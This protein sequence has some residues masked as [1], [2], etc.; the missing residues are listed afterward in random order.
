MKKLFTILFWGILFTVGLNFQSQAQ[1]CPE[2]YNFNTG[3]SHVILVN[4]PLTLDGNAI[5]TSPADDVYVAAFYDSSGY[6]RCAGYSIWQGV[7]TSITAWGQESTAIENGYAAGELLKFKFC[8]NGD[9]YD[10]TP[11]FSFGPSTYSTNGLSGLC[12]LS[13]A[14][15]INLE[16]VDWIGPLS[17]CGLGV[18]SVTV[19]IWNDTL[20]MATGPFDISYSIDNGVNWVTETYTGS[21]TGQDTLVYTFST[22]ANFSA[23][24][25]TPGNPQDSV[26][27]VAFQITFTSDMDSTD[28]YF[29]GTVTNIVPPQVNITNSVLELCHPTNIAPILLTASPSGGTFSFDMSSG[30]MYVIGGSFFPS[31]SGPGQW[32]VYYD[33]YDQTTGCTG[34]DTVVFSV[35]ADPVTHITNT[36]LEGC[37][38]DTIQINATPAGGT[39]TGTWVDPT[40]GVFTP[41]SPNTYTI[42][43]SYTDIHGCSDNTSED[44][45]IHSLPSVSLDFFRAQCTDGQPF[46]LD[47]QPANGVFEVDQTVLPS[48]EFNPANFST[49]THTVYYTYTD[50]YG[51]SKQTS[52]TIKIF[53]LPNVNFTGLDAEYCRYDAPVTL[54]GTP[55]NGI[56]SGATSTNIFDPVNIG[57]QSITYTYTQDNQFYGDTA[58]C[59]NHNTQSTTV[60]AL[61]NIDISAAYTIN[62]WG[63]ISTGMPDSIILNAGLGY[64]AYEWNTG[65]TT[66]SITNLPWGTYSCSVTDDHSC[67]GTD[68]VI[69]GGLDIS[70]TMLLNPVSN[71]EQSIPQEF[72]Y[73]TKNSGSWPILPGSIISLKGRFD[74]NPVYSTQLPP[75]TDTLQAGDSIIVNLGQNVDMTGLTNVGS[76]TVLATARLIDPLGLQP[77]DIDLHN[78]SLY[79]VIENGGV[80][81][82]DLGV[83]ITSGSPDTIVLEAGIYDEYLWSNGA[84]TQSISLPYFN[85]SAEYCVTVTDQY[86]CTDEDCIKIFNSID[87]PADSYDKLNVFPNP[88]NGRFTIE[89]ALKSVSELK[90]DLIDLQGRTIKEITNSKTNYFNQEFNLNTLPAGIYFLKI[91]NGMD[92]HFTKI[93]IE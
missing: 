53:A 67:V 75:L 56:W 23:L 39:F 45:L 74:T 85:N 12:G 51:C 58:H 69:I 54:I 64:S 2:L 92:Q 61:P 50:Q 78:D 9:L 34:T 26:Y 41:L 1:S 37:Q 22:P 44:F 15:A 83:D 82:V 80:P 76:Y 88:N 6:E 10:A 18:D 65:A 25:G 55:S 52:K 17:G 86:G 79:T 5:P 7:T 90:I 36:I 60:W 68:E 49:G 20:G 21:I 31:E 27:N 11:C 89:V 81:V 32:P 4:P 35:W 77:G 28:N 72:K 40:S 42:Q 63:F 73:V 29:S 62:P 30:V 91:F 46:N 19:S 14:N 57:N 84:T 87:D 59:T 13:A 93:V 16:V 38:Y 43:Y 48:A 24:A 70:A 71:C 47:G 8:I 66:F 3:A 33:F